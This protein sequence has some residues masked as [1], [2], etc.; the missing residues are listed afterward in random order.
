ARLCALESSK[1]RRT[2]L[3]NGN[4]RRS[5]RLAHRVLRDGHEIPR[6]NAGHTH[7]RDRP[8]FPAP[9][10][11]NR[12]KR[13]RNGKAVF[14][15]LAP[16]RTSSRRRRKDVQIAR[17]FLYIARSFRKRPQAF[18]TPICPCQRP[19]STAAQFHVRR[20]ATSSEFRRAPPHFLR[21]F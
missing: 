5:P 1:T 2:F 14:A 9:R 8:C 4:W 20:L 11:R 21:S 12:A 18:F 10:K 17:Q 19:V 3:G 16:C 13:R 6:R 7:G 15:L